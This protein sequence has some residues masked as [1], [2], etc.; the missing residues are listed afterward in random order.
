MKLS[1]K[2]RLLL[3]LLTICM[4]DLKFL[5]NLFVSSNNCSSILAKKYNDEINYSKVVNDILPNCNLNNYS[6]TNIT[7]SSIDNIN[8]CLDH[9]ITHGPGRE[10][11]GLDLLSEGC[12]N[13]KGYEYGNYGT[14]NIPY[15]INMSSINTIENDHKKIL[16][17]DIKEQTEL[18]NNA[19]MHDGTGKI[20]NLYEPNPNATTLPAN[21]NDLP[22]IEIKRE[23]GNYYG[24]FYY[25]NNR[26]V[27]NYNS[28]QLNAGRSADTIL[29][30][31]GHVLGLG[32]LET[33]VESTQGIHKSIMAYKRSE[34]REDLPYAMKYKISK[35]LQY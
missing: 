26:I 33:N 17:N 29:H 1:K 28:K 4:M 24:R 2:H 12:R 16:L 13:Y 30:E 25:E 35:V 31:F 14:I 32:D 11:G 6:S 5:P 21:I 15:W 22:V 3:I 7:V 20:I 27:F 34:S 9:S 19:E 10:K 18:W 23:D 8:D